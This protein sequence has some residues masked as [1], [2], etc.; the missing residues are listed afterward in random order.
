LCYSLCSHCLYFEWLRCPNC[1]SCNETTGVCEEGC[2]PDG[3]CGGQDQGDFCCLA[4]GA[5]CEPFYFN[6]C[7]SFNCNGPA[8]GPFTCLP[9]IRG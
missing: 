9:P 8:G 4:E 7:C 6:R 1:T 2:G 5:V 3:I